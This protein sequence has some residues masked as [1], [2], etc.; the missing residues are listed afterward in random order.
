VKKVRWHCHFG[1]QQIPAEKGKIQ[2]CPGTRQCVSFLSRTV[3]KSET[4]VPKTEI[5]FAAQVVLLGPSR[6]RKSG[7]APGRR[8]EAPWTACD[9][10]QRSHRFRTSRRWNKSKPLADNCGMVDLTLV[11]RSSADDR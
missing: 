6:G 9:G 1:R 4:P 5:E 3:T 7:L 11:T 10:A 8:R 2:N